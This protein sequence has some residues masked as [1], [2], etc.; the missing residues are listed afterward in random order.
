M[1]GKLKIGIFS[2]ILIL[3]L[4]IGAGIF[5]IISKPADVLEDQI[6]RLTG[7][8]R[9]LLY[10]RG[11]LYRYGIAGIHIPTSILTTV[12][13]E[14]PRLV[15]VEYAVEKYAE[16]DTALRGSLSGYLSSARS[17]TEKYT[18]LI[19]DYNQLG[20]AKPKPFDAANLEEIEK[21]I[22]THIRD[23]ESVRSA[24]N[25]ISARYR[26]RAT[27]LSG[28]LITVTWILGLFVT[29]ALAKTIYTI[30]LSYNAK[31][32]IILKAG[33]RIGSADWGQTEPHSSE[34]VFTKERTATFSEF[35]GI[36]TVSDN[37]GGKNENKSP[38]RPLAVGAGSFTS[39][40]RSG[41]QPDTRLISAA[42]KQAA[43]I[44]KNTQ[45][46]KSLSEL[47]QS[48]S[49]LE[50]RHTDLQTVYQDMQTAAEK[51]ASTYKKSATQLQEILSAV[52]ETAE[53][54]RND[55][56]TAKKLVETFNSGHQLFK[57]THDHMQF[58]IQNVSK[59]QEMSEI[60]ENIAEQ[61][62]MLSM[63]AAI[64]A[65][66]A[67]EAGKGFAVVAEELSRLAAAA[68]ESSHDIGGTIKQVVSVITNIGTTGDEL[69]RAFEKIHL[70][71]DSIYTS[72]VDFSS[73]IEQT[74]HEAKTTLMHFS[75]L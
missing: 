47:Q 58:I 56:E 15:A 6:M 20:A 69:D 32:R 46:E 51:E 13:E 12:S 19:N 57:T 62:K 37:A 61:T 53:A 18:N 52:Q 2:G 67:G 29:W 21:L 42:E 24:L 60:I 31:K 43:L 70:Q 23:F 55:S 5:M 68:L 64:E 35:S 28:I 50:K 25:A 27:I 30:L 44:E 75:A 1:N 49:V 8:E 10:I 38:N 7:Y 66:H 17:I 72:L 48:Y 33:P 63:N 71:T 45:L 36:R 14:E 59:I 11:T 16:K 54:H 9:H 39:E 74:G 41:G 65:A 22:D 34:S 3:L 40:R 73:K 26:N 4:L